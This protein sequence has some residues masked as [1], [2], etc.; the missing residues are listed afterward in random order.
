[1][2]E[3]DTTHRCPGPGP[4]PERVPD[5]R[6]ACPAHWDLVPKALRD[7]VE[8]ADRAQ[9]RAQAAWSAADLALLEAGKRYDLANLAAIRAMEPTS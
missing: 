3:P 8:D 5:D 6:L 7:E 2:P 9:E 4:C 1:M